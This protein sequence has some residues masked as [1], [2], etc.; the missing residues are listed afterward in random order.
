MIFRGR[1]RP[2][3]RSVS[4]RTLFWLVR[5]EAEL[6]VMY[7]PSNEWLRV[8]HVNRWIKLTSTARRRKAAAAFAVWPERRVKP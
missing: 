2:R 6:W 7:G 3:R 4:F 8:L 1:R 5:T